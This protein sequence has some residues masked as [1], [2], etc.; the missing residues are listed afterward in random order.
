MA[1]TSATSSTT[2]TGNSSLG[3]ADYLK[4]LVTQLT[5]QNPLNPQSDTAFAA[6]LAQFSALQETQALDTNLQSLQ[7]SSLIGLTVALQS[8]TNS[9]G[10]DI[11]VVS[12][13]QIIAGKPNLIVNGNPY[14]MSQLKAITAT[15]SQTAT[16]NSGSNASTDSPTTG[17]TATQTSTGVNQSY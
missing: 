3:Q 11:G 2:P 6:Q 1:S 14:S 7:A 13:V 15:T 9:A 5:S 8:S 16:A 10:T 12:S 4:L 17:S